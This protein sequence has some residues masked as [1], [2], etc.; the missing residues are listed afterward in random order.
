MVEHAGFAKGQQTCRA[1]RK[2]AGYNDRSNFSQGKTC[3][4]CGVRIANTNIGGHCMTHFREVV[5]VRKR[6][7]RPRRYLN[8]YGYVVI[9]SQWDHPNC[10]K[11][12][13]IL[14]HTMVMAE[15]LG[16]PLYPGENV[17]HINGVRDDNRPE[18]LELWVRSQPSGQR[19]QDLVAWAR[20]IIERY[21]S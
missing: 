10:N 20:E 6:K 13:H 7:T 9:T 2:S 14:E 12:G 18:N 16:R 11:R 21:G 17:H 5:E 1:C 19:P 4:V 8:A 3:K 15:K